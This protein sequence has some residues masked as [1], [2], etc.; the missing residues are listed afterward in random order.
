[1]NV[2]QV[3]EKIIYW[4]YTN[5]N[6]FLTKNISILSFY[7]LNL[8]AKKKTFIAFIH[9]IIPIFKMAI[10]FFLLLVKTVVK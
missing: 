7:F 1:M 6:T 2:M 3:I 8:L 4:N 10:L 5:V 9:T